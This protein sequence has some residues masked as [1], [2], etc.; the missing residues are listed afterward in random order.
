MPEP[1]ITV[2]QD[3][4]DDYPE[5]YKGGTWS[6][7]RQRILCEIHATN[8]LETLDRTTLGGFVRWQYFR[9]RL[10]RE[11]AKWLTY[12]VVKRRWDM[13][14]DCDASITPHDPAL[15]RLYRQLLTAVFKIRRGKTSPG[16]N[17]RRRM[18]TSTGPIFVLGAPRSG[19]TL[20]GCLLNKHP[21]CF[22]LFE[23]AIF[24]DTYRKWYRLTAR[25]GV[26]GRDAFV[27]LMRTGMQ[28]AEYN[29]RAGLDDTALRDCAEAGDGQFNRMFD[30]YMAQGHG[31]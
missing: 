19:N 28:W 30:A 31:M 5:S 10:A 24:S 1:L 23:R 16:K 11:T 27:S 13:I 8:R 18:T 12:A 26:S 3:R 7:P 15:L 22:I 29:E 17:G 6:W 20:I 2:R 9:L 4:P 21:A 14:E 25:G